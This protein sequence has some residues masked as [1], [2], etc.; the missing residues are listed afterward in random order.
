[1]SSL[2]GTVQTFGEMVNNLMVKFIGW[3]LK[4]GID[5]LNLLLGPSKQSAQNVVADLQNLLGGIAKELYQIILTLPGMRTICETVLYAVHEVEDGFCTAMTAKFVPTSVRF[6]NSYNG[7]SSCIRPL[8]SAIRFMS[9][10]NAAPGAT[11]QVSLDIMAATAAIPT[12]PTPI[13]NIQ[14][15]TLPNSFITPLAR[16][17]RERRRDERSRG[18][19]GRRGSCRFE[20]RRDCIRVPLRA[21]ECVCMCGGIIRNK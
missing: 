15:I 8:G 9:N 4:L 14:P 21:S 16:P 10:V 11:K 3:M 5:F 1:M 7:T 6:C 18:G 17:P 19:R 12:V 20:Q 2:V 13:G